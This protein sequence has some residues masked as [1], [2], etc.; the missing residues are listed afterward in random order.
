MLTP[1]PTCRPGYV[2]Q[3]GVA[4]SESILSARSP[5]FPVRHL[6]TRP[7]TP[8]CLRRVRNMAPSTPA[9]AVSTSIG[10]PISPVHLQAIQ[11]DC[12]PTKQHSC[13]APTPK[14][15]TSHTRPGTQASTALAAPAAATSLPLKPIPPPLHPEH[16]AHMLTQLLAAAAASSERLAKKAGTGGL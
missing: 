12:R 5:K 6:A 14:L 7:C 2:L 16:P 8:A 10:R 11:G 9:P 13:H 1:C 4:A 15:P 3:T